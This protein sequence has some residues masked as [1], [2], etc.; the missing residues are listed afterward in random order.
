MPRTT[1]TVTIDAAAKASGT[2]Q[3]YDDQNALIATF[4]AAGD[5]NE[6]NGKDTTVGRSGTLS[7]VVHWNPQ[8]T[9]SVVGRYNGSALDTT[10]PVSVPHDG[11]G[12][13]HK[14]AGA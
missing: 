12:R 11:Q 6:T 8:V 13:H 10:V 1:G 2:V 3:L 5:V 7:L 4:D 14:S 9:G